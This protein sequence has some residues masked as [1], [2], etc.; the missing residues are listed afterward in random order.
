[1]PSVEPASADW[2]FAAGGG[3]DARN[4][5]LR[6]RAHNVFEAELFFG[7][8]TVRERAPAWVLVEDL[9]ESVVVTVRDEGPGIP[10]GRVGKL[11][12]RAEWRSDP[13]GADPAQV[14]VGMHVLMYD[15]AKRLRMLPGMQKTLLVALTGWGT[16]DDRQRTR[17]AGFDRH[18]SK[19][20]KPHLLLEA[21]RQCC[22]PATSA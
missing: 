5:Q 16:Q 19:P 10:D 21:I 3:A 11:P 13:R 8:S 18:L 7:P 22:P 4:I 12:T 15:V 14:R 1:M 17:D 6:C 9:G 2:P 20:L